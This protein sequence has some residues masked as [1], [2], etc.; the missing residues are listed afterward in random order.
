MKRIFFVIASIILALMFCSCES[1]DSKQ[2]KP[3]KIEVVGFNMQ[4]A[5]KM[6]EKGDK[7]IADISKKDTVS[8]QEYNQFLGNI[9]EIYDKYEGGHWEYIFFYN[10]EFEDKEI[11][12]LHL[13][14]DMFYPTIYHEDVEVVSAQIINSYYLNES[15]NTSILTIREEYLGEDSKLDGW[16]REYVYIKNDKNKWIFNNFGGQMNFLDEGFKSDYLAFKKRPEK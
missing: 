5:Q 8:R 12:T 14:K 1:I 3:T 10:T 13:N 4:I 6:I 15:L 2:T 9:A 11:E 16:Y 7:I